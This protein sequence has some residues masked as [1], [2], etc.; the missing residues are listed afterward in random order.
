M[1]MSQQE[2]SCCLFKLFFKFCLLL[3]LFNEHMS[4]SRRVS[5]TQIPI[6]LGSDQLYYS[7]NAGYGS[8]LGPSSPPIP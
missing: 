8:G 7:K 1:L 6:S 2:Y 4:L 3:F 5:P